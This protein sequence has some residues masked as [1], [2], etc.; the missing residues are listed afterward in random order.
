MIHNYQ[1]TLGAAPKD[2][3]LVVIDAQ[4]RLVPAMH[5]GEKTSANIA[6]IIQVSKLLNV[7][8]LVTEQYPKGLGTTI[9]A[10]AKA[11]P[12]DAR[13]L[14]KTSFSCW[15]AEGFEEAV[16]NSRAG[17][18]IVVGMETHVCVQ[19]TVLE[20]LHRDYEVILLA[21]GVCSRTP[22]N[23]ELAL[24]LMRRA[25]AIVTSTE[26]LIFDWVQSASHPNFKDISKLLK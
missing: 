5:Q 16:M 3:M 14:E 19:Q 10:V 22:E 26:S 1:Y 2:S 18:L 25:G 11:F 6:K 15:G 20:A 24:E 9:P 12:E 4:E 21:D 8:M 13:I 7:D 23:R 17:A